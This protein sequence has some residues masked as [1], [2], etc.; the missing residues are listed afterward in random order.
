MND[1]SLQIMRQLLRPATPGE[2]AATIRAQTE[3]E[4]GGEQLSLADAD[5]EDEVHKILACRDEN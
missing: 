4:S 5:L 1:V 2:I 3:L